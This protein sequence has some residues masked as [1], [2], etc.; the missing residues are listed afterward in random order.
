MNKVMQKIFLVAAIVA[1]LAPVATH[2]KPHSAPV[3]N[4]HQEGLSLARQQE[5]LNS[6]APSIRQDQFGDFADVLSAAGI[7]GLDYPFPGGQN[8]F[9]DA[10]RSKTLYPL[11]YD[12]CLRWAPSWKVWLICEGISQ[13]KRGISAA[14][15]RHAI[16]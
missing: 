11:R 6:V 2:A 5:F 16:I 3:Q 9:V 1:I 15:D 12:F 8:N 14:L 4:T 10:L 7:F 13:A